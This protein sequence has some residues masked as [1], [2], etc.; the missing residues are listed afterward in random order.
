MKI[1]FNIILIFLILLACKNIAQ[2]TQSNDNI[3]KEE[4]SIDLIKDTLKIIN[5]YEDEIKIILKNKN[6][7]Y[8]N[9]NI[10]ADSLDLKMFSLK[11]FAKILYFPIFDDSGEPYAKGAFFFNDNGYLI[12]RRLF[13]NDKELNIKEATRLYL[14]NNTVISYNITFDKNEI[15]TTRINKH[16][17][18]YLEAC[19][20]RDVDGYLFHF[21]DI[22]YTL[23]IPADDAG[24]ILKTIF[25]KTPLMKEPSQFSEVIS[26]IPNGTGLRYIKRSEKVD[27]IGERTW[28]WI[29]VETDKKEKGWI[30]GH[31]DF[32]KEITDG[33]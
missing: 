8:S 6:E 12:A 27:T 22:K 5:N 2:K 14:N 7:Y 31:P 29:Y 19:A 33:D 26:F 15:K 11:K 30:F 4:S 21:N 9:K 16:I 10:Q 17:Q 28:I 1:G 23:P 13:Y 24:N 32:V 3:K 20:I 25:P 18:H